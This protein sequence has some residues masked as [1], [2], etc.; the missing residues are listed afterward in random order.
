MKFLIYRDKVPCIFDVFPHFITFMHNFY[1][2]IFSDKSS[3][4]IRMLDYPAFSIK[5]YPF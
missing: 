1:F 3:Y 5:K 4:F 2:F